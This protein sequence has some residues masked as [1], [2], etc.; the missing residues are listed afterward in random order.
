MGA[1]RG[2]WIFTAQ[3]VKYIAMCLKGSE[4]K[5]VGIVLVS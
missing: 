4:S 2:A 5:T 1:S 3:L